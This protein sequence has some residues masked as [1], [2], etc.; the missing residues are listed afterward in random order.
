[1][2]QLHLHTLRN[3]PFIP[4]GSSLLKPSRLFMSMDGGDL[5]PFMF[6]MP[7]QFQSYEKLFKVLGTKEK[8]SIKD[9]H[10][11]LLELN[12]ECGANKPLN[13]NELN[14]VFKV[15]ELI[16]KQIDVGQRIEKLLVPSEMGVLIWSD[17]CV[18]NDDTYLSSRINRGTAEFSLVHSAL[19][20]SICQKLN[21]LPLSKAI[22]EKLE[23][24]KKMEVSTS[25]NVIHQFIHRNNEALCMNIERIIRHHIL[26]AHNKD[27]YSYNKLNLP[28][29]EMISSKLK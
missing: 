1:M 19:K 2:T 21:I 5:S 29:K 8:P 26:S 3:T 28:T 14:A 25:D 15:I 4:I 10:Q 13:I 27:Q 17:V 6:T 9:Y 24:F 22:V 7:R 23:K 18:Y 20:L 16:C 11:F 12:A